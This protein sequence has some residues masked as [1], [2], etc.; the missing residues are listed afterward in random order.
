MLRSV[1][2]VITNVK[3]RDDPK[4]LGRWGLFCETS[5]NIKSSLAN[6]DSCGDH[7]CGDP[8]KAKEIISYEYGKKQT[9]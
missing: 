4:P 2:K 8:L 3:I 9:K 5:S 6:H 1:L 7:L